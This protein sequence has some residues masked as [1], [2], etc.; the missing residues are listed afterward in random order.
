LDTALVKR[1]SKD[2]ALMETSD[3]FDRSASGKAT[4]QTT[5]SRAAKFPN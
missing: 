1:P 3:A 2:A 5:R 4:A